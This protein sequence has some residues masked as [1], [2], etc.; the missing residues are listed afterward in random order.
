M[1]SSTSTT[2]STPHPRP[3]KKATAP[4]A[5]RTPVRGF[6]VPDD[7]YLP[8]QQ[9][10]EAEGGDLSTVVR[11]ALRRYGRAAAKR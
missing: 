10:A 8:A 5:G 4:P 9:R 3:A 7:I 11:A 1:A 6:R 2:I